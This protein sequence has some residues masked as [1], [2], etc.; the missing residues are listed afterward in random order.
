MEYI[1]NL[2]LTVCAHPADTHAAE[3][4]GL[5]LCHLAYRIGRDG[6]L[7]RSGLGIT[8]RG[9]LLGISDIGL[10]DGTEYS[11]ALPRELRRECDIRGFEGVFCDFE[12]SADEF[13]TRF[14]YEAGI[15]FAEQGLKLYLPERF[16]AAAHQAHL[17]IPSAVVGAT[18]DEVYRRAVLRY[19][20]DR[21]A[22]VYEPL[23]AD[24]VMPAPCG[25]QK[26]LTRAELAGLMA[27][28][29]AVGYMS[30]ELCARYF[31]YRD[32]DGRSRFVL[33]DDTRTMQRKLSLAEKCGF[34]E[35]FI[36]WPDYSELV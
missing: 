19:G 12:G 13:R 3:A 26:N 7:Y 10:A 32:G 30:Q 17:L 5:P 1:N 23:C 20:S 34:K 14:A 33:F 11:D 9:G 29:H 16:A 36:S 15:Y 24:F 35:A 18:C 27:R 6:H 2:K 4:A 8:V 31:T 28:E 25:E 21:C 22:L